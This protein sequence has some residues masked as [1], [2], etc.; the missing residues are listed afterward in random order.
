MIPVG[1]RSSVPANVNGKVGRNWYRGQ[2]VATF[3]AGSTE[4]FQ[5][6]PGAESFNAG[7]NE[8]SSFVREN[9]PDAFGLRRQSSST[10]PEKSQCFRMFRAED[11]QP[12]RCDDAKVR[13]FHT[14]VVSRSRNERQECSLPT[15][16]FRV[17]RYCMTSNRCATLNLKRDGDKSSA[18]RYGIGMVQI[19]IIISALGL[20]SPEEP[21]LAFSSMLALTWLSR[22]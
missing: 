9:R 18:A 8:L 1:Y 4:N 16:S 3:D 13:L 14:P 5:S 20:L 11:F 7:A 12:A 2:Q 21:F 6:R 19:S 10:S 15:K 17:P 22:R